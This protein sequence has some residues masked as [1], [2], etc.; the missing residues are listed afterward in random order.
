MMLGLVQCTMQ[1]SH[2][3]E[4][5]RSDILILASRV[6]FPDNEDQTRKPIFNLTLVYLRNFRLSG[7]VFSS[8]FK[9]TKVVPFIPAG[10]ARILGRVAHSFM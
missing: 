1:Q 4:T 9:C 6:Y 3:R 2:L 8:N 10:F 7:P 5:G